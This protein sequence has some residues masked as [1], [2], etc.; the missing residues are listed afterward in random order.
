MAT[1]NVY[2]LYGRTK[3]N[4][5][6]HEKQKIGEYEAQKATTE[7]GGRQWTAWFTEAIPFPDGHINLW[8]PV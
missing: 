8:F 2:E 5:K 1:A 7:F 6:I 3:F 4:G